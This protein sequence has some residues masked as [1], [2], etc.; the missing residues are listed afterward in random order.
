MEIITSHVNSDFDTIASMLAASKLYPAAY[1]VLPGAK[2]GTVN[3][4]LLKSTIYA[5][6][7]KNAKEIDPGE[8]KR[9]VL[10]DIRN[11]S[12][13]GIFREIVKKKEVD[14]HIYDH[15]PDEEADILADFEVIEEVGA[16]TTLLVE[17]LREKKIEITPDEA[18]VMML[19]IYED[20]GFL[21]YASTTPRDFRAATYLLE[22]GADLAIV[23]DILSR[24][25]TA[26]QVYLLY[27]F[28]N[29]SKVH[30]IHGVDV[31]IAEA[32]REVYIKDIAVVVH[33][34]RDIESINVLITICQLGDRTLIVGRSRLKEVDVGAA[35]RE[36]GGGG[37]WYAAS[38]TV[39]ELTT[40]Q[41]RE[42]ILSILY[43]KVIPEK[44]ADALMAG[45]VK[46]VEENTPLAEVHDT[47]TRFNINSL[48][49]TEGG[50][51]AGIITRQVVEKALYHHLE[52]LPVRDYMTTDFE[53]VER[54]A[55]LDR[56]QDILIGSNQ[57]ILPVVEEGAILGVITRTDLIRYLHDLREISVLEERKR[58]EKYYSRKKIISGLMKE[59]LPGRIMKLLKNLGKTGDRVGMKIYVVGGFV[60]DLLLR[61]DNY[62]IDIV[63]EG[64]GISFAE[65]IAKE[66][67]CRVRSHQKFGTAMVIFP[68][69]FKIDVATARVEYYREPAA[70]PVVEYS[71]IKHDL[72]RRDFTIN[73]LAVSLNKDHFGEVIDFFGGQRDIK[74]GL[75]RVLHSLS[76]VEDPT[77]ILR[78]LRF[79]KRFYFQIGKNTR[80]LIRNAVRLGLLEKVP[81]P[82]VYA[83]LE[84]I[85]NEERVVE[86]IE[87]MGR[88]KIGSALHGKITLD[89]EQVELLRDVREVCVWFNLLYLDVTYDGWICYLLA[90]LDPLEGEDAIVCAKKMG[91][92]RKVMDVIRATK[93]EA[94]KVIYT[95]LTSRTISKKGIYDLLKDLPIETIL[96]MMAKAK[97]EDIRRY[98]SMYFTHLRNVKVSLDGNDLIALGLSPGPLFKDIFNEVHEKK[99]SGFLKT[100]EQ[101]LKFVREKYGN[102]AGEE[103]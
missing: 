30:T 69:G 76:F 39:K 85:L 28:I 82:R 84:L 35:L 31:V 89:G 71:S 97:S 3:D 86:I 57:R 38:A 58:G 75:I 93:D 12:R 66:L 78:A 61:Q 17:I 15:H 49:V 65:I 77:R 36:L 18:T 40:I 16:T 92:R 100:R 32:K 50:K 9:V 6:K 103:R 101:E 80:G 41:I 43:G 7:M 25:L 23:R 102:S 27:D 87:E 79:E 98:I 67:P 91:I 74:D 21:S 60:R 11:S 59:R 44:H 55:G 70:L 56:V 8:I 94:G 48:P 22:R 13:I 34:L 90:L 24:D 47:L 2:E 73:A 81:L 29:S 1:I 96:Y 52:N 83:D 51:M 88:L 64:D 26:E 42:K 10:V 99:I 5:F 68:D 54:G 4:F 20:T 53:T 37:H 33:K 72:Y 46:T 14:V 62:D 63:V 19:G 45:P 95:F